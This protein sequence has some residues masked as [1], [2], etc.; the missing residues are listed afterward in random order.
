MQTYFMEKTGFVWLLFYSF[1]D[2]LIVHVFF[3]FFHLTKHSIQC[4][5]AFIPDR[6]LQ[7]HEMNNFNEMKQI[8]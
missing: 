2:Q 6:K 7:M 8:H 4:I 5:L 1:L 3:Y